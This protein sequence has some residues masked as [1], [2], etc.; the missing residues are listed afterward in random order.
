MRASR[1]LGA[2]VSSAFAALPDGTD[3]PTHGL[4]PNVGCRS[5]PASIA[6][7]SWPAERTLISTR[8]CLLALVEETDT[9]ERPIMADSPPR[10]GMDSASVSRTSEPSGLATSRRRRRMPL[11]SFRSP[12]SSLAARRRKSS[13]PRTMRNG[14]PAMT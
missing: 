6:S 3:W 1:T 2:P 14:A 11:F 13:E 4:W 12:S 7:R 5:I 8:G 10:R 9:L